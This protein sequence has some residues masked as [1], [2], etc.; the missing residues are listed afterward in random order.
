MDERERN[1]PLDPI[2]RVEQQGN[3]RI[4]LDDSRDL[5]AR[6]PLTI[7]II[8]REEQQPSEPSAPAAV[9]II[10]EDELAQMMDIHNAR[11]NEEDE[12]MTFGESITLLI[13]IGVLLYLIYALLWPE[14][15]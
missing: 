15:F 7:R 8:V 3:V 9:R 13:A 11:I 10:H 6:K 1:R 2:H 14:R 4:I 12:P 5:D